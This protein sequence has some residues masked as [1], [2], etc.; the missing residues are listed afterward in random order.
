[1][2]T[3]LIGHSGFVG[4]TLGRQ[5]V[6]EHKFRS[7]DIGDI[8]G[9]SFDLAVCAAAPAQK[10][11]ANADPDADRAAIDGLIAHLATVRVKTFVLISTVD[12]FAN[13]RGVDEDT[14]V[15]TDGLHPYGLNRRRLEQF[16]QEQFGR[17]L[18]VRLPG[19]VGPGLQKNVV[20]DLLHDN[21]LEAVDSRGVFQFYPMVN[22][23][24]D[25][26]CALRAGLSLAH[27]TAEPVDV[28]SVAGEGFGRTFANHLDRPVARYDFRTKHAEAF[29]GAGAYQYTARESLGA[30]RSYAQSA[31]AAAEPLS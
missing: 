21:N 17:H 3:A 23:W 12:V 26:R 29:G 11:K 9:R 1:V 30:I 31:G 25:V 4:S 27:L 10:W 18:V 28:A 7:T 15:L 6:F 2:T 16:V 19:L 22:L 8:D 24:W 14:E 13:P 20:F 5:T